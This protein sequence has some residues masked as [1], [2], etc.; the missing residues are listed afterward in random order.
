MIKKVIVSA[1]LFISLYCTNA[2]CLDFSYSAGI[3]NTGSKKYKAVRLTPEVYNNIQENMADLLVYDKNNE[4]VPYFVNSFIESKAETNLSYEMK[5]VN[6][7]VKDEYFYYDYTVE[8]PQN[9]DVTATSIEVQTG[10]GGFAKNVELY[11]GYDNK[12]WEKIKDDI[13]Y[14]VNDSEK[15]QVTFGDVKK[16]TCY[17]FKIS[18][19]LENVAFS[20]VALKYNTVQQKKEYFIDTLAPKFTTEDKEN[21][22]VIKVQ[23]LKNLKLAS[24]TLK[25]DDMFKRKATFDSRISKMLYNLEFQNTKYRDLTIPLDEYK[26]NSDTAEIITDNKDDKPIKVLGIETKYLADELIFD[27]S[28]SGEY[29]L[30]FGSSKMVSPK[31][32]DISNYRE[33]ILKDGYDVLSIG[34]IK[35]ENP[36][37]PAEPKYKLIFNI[38]IFVVALVM[39]IIVFLKLKK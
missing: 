17:R 5:L 6:S 16:Y 30:R 21:T 1:L 25:T 35:I 27:G 18:N 14:K 8:N 22:T 9:E 31:S 33:Q 10:S 7:F 37:T 29:T 3:K 11:G 32:Y 12:N 34:S 38:T 19:N 13:L 26:I 36:Q 23:G 39:G 15:L 20:S 24:I 4:T 2:Y 28:K